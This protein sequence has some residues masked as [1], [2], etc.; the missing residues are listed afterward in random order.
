M[1][2]IVLAAGLALAYLWRRQ[3]RDPT[4]TQV[5]FVL[6]AFSCVLVLWAQYVVSEWAMFWGRPVIDWIPIDAF[7]VGATLGCVLADQHLVKEEPRRS[8]SD[9][10]GSEDFEGRPLLSAGAL[11]VSI[12]LSILLIAGLAPSQSWIGI[13]ERVQGVKAAG[14]EVSLAASQGTDL[15]RDIRSA[16]P[17]R[18]VDAS[19]GPVVTERTGFVPVRLGMMR[20]YTFP[21]KLE[22]HS[23]STPF[24]DSDLYILSIPA[25]VL[26]IAANQ[27]DPSP[28]T[29]R[30]ISRDRA[31]AWKLERADQ[32]NTSP[33]TPPSWMKNLGNAQQEFLSLLAPHIDCLSDFVKQ[34]NNRRLLEY[35]NYGIVAD[36]FSLAHYWSQ[37]EMNFLIARQDNTQNTTTHINSL[38]QQQITSIGKKFESFGTFSQQFLRVWGSESASG[39]D[40]EASCFRQH[41]AA[42]EIKRF[43]TRFRRTNLESGWFT[44][45]LSVFVAQALSA[46]GDHASAINLLVQWMSDLDKVVEHAQRNS[47]KNPSLGDQSHRKLADWYRLQVFDAILTLQRLSE[48]S[49]ISIPQ[50][51]IGLRAMVERYFPRMFKNMGEST[52]IPTWRSATLGCT[53]SENKWKQTIIFSYVTWIKQYLDV[54]VQRGDD[55]NDD[56]L[57]FANILEELNLDCFPIYYDKMRT[58]AGLPQA[59]QHLQFVTTAAAVRFAR[60]T[61]SREDQTPEDRRTLRQRSEVSLRQAII[62]LEQAQVASK[63]AT[64]G[65]QVWVFGAVGGDVLTN[66]R[67]LK[68]RLGDPRFLR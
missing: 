66:A 62:K 53:T 10:S 36:L 55:I 2:V 67:N 45:Y 51:T 7:A 42:N 1:R 26:E 61:Q 13:L 49:D 64:D 60:L 58:D 63:D 48:G 41:I 25:D 16:A 11:P 50:T 44:P 29:V 34:T 31:I 17:P 12:S 43:A 4:L 37:E 6:F 27:I 28:R 18:P 30:Q 3:R 9:E 52:N 47:G 19:F 57:R 14:V 23:Q 21:A 39:R 33:P 38:L 15:A 8:E 35:Q 24:S 22:G 54:A 65:L 68:K 32:A 5:S 56:D 40:G 46:M 20:A 59:E